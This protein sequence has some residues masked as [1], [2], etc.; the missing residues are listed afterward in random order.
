M[1]LLAEETNFGLENFEKTDSP[2]EPSES[3]LWH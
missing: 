1:L 3:V 2:T